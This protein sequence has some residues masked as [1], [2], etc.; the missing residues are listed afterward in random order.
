MKSLLFLAK[1]MAPEDRLPCLPS[2]GRGREK[3]GNLVVGENAKSFTQ[4]KGL[5]TRS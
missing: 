5:F 3:E 4:L 1:A 2:L